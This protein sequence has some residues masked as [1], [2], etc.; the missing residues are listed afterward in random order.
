MEK[1]ISRRKLVMKQ[2]LRRNNRWIRVLACMAVVLCMPGLFCACGKKAGNS[3]LGDY[4]KYLGDY[5]YDCSIS[6]MV[7]ET[8]EGEEEPGILYRQ[9]TDLD[10]LSK[11]CPIP[12][13]FFFYSGMHAD[14]YGLFACMEQVAEQYHDKVLIVTIDALAEK[15]LS[16]AYKI[17]ALPEAIV[18]RDNR[19]KARFEGQNRGEWTAQELADWIVTEVTN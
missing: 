10:A 18:I 7:F 17:E 2:C 4:H 19:Q 16:A 13:C 3:D 5:Y 11:S 1:C 9:V 8:P 15:D 12:I 14:V 6:A